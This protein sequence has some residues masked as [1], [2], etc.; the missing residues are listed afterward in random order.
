MTFQQTKKPT[1]SVSMNKFK[2]P[3]KFYEKNYK[4]GSL[5]SKIKNKVQI[6]LSGTDHTVTT[7][8]NKVIHRKLISNP[9]PFQ[10]TITT[11]TKRI[12]T[13]QNEQPSCSKT[14][15]ATTVG[16]N[17]CIYMRKETPGLINH[18]RSEDWLKRKEQSRNNKGQFTSPNRSPGETE[19]DLNLS[20][21]SDKEFDCYNESDGKPVHANIEDELQLLPKDNK[22][23]PGQGIYKEKK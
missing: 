9:V 3:F 6:A 10:Q 15:D 14:L 4:K 18:E 22:L 7:N 11:P 1:G 17:P 12:T 13:R 19:T 5:D 23:T 20:I 21:V 8:K 16:G 2:N